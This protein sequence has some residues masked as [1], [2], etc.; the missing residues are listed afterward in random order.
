MSTALMEPP[1]LH[2]DQYLLIRPITTNLKGALDKLPDT[3]GVDIQGEPQPI[4]ENGVI[5][6]AIDTI[7][8]DYAFNEPLDGLSLL[9]IVKVA[10]YFD[11]RPMLAFVTDKWNLYHQHLHAYVDLV[12]IDNVVEMVKSIA[13]GY[14][15]CI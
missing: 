10:A 3:L 11:N 2:Q 7:M 8:L 5:I 9:I 13:G 1:Q 12:S 15:H 4:K 14:R 6:G